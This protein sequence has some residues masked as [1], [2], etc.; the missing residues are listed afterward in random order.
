[1]GVFGRIN[2][3]LGYMLLSLFFS[4]IAYSFEYTDLSPLSGN[5]LKILYYS[6]GISD[7]IVFF[8]QI[9]CCYMEMQTIFFLRIY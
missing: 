7:R 1:M 5:L 2:C 4:S 3:S 9:A 8:F 6:Y